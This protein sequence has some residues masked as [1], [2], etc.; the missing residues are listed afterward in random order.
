M[1]EKDV[2]NREKLYSEFLKEVA[3]LYGYIPTALA[4]AL[5]Y[6]LVPI[7]F[8]HRCVENGESATNQPGGYFAASFLIVFIP[9]KVARILR[10]FSKALLEKVDSLCFL[11]QSQ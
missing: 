4:L 3:D 1:R 7:G 2:A 9:R 10:A 8:G 6:L 5:W 11:R